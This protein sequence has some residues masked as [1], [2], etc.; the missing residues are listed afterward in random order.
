MIVMV[1]VEER[2]RLFSKA[3]AATATA[4]GI[5]SNAFYR[6]QNFQVIIAAQIRVAR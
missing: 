4:R 5:G 2:N 6:A 3:A 1:E